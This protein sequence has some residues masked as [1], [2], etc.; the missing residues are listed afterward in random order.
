[1]KDKV[2]HPGHT[3][4]EI[5]VSYTRNNIKEK[6]IREEVKMQLGNTWVEL[7]KSSTILFLQLLTL[8]RVN[9]HLYT[10]L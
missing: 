4:G 10:A 3:S 8:K 2:S 6:E 5:T 9:M 1:M 7:L